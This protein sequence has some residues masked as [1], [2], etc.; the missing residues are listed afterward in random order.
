MTEELKRDTSSAGLIL[1][2][3]PWCQ[4]LLFI[5]PGV[6]GYSG[7]VHLLIGLPPLSG[8]V[9]CLWPLQ[10]C[11]QCFLYIW[12]LAMTALNFTSGMELPWPQS[13][14]VPLLDLSC[15]CRC[16]HSLSRLFHGRWPQKFLLKP[17]EFSGKKKKKTHSPVPSE[18]TLL[19]YCPRWA[20]QFSDPW[21]GALHSFSKYLANA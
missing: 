7:P 18:D 3:G 21:K 20:F 19:T 2:V 8:L 12:A 1:H 5:P 10:T 11:F 9:T 6:R 14:I 15:L 13:A 17:T 4:V 16:L